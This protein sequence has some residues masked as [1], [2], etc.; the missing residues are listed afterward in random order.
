[1]ASSSSSHSSSSSSKS[2]SSSSA[3]SSSSSPYS[4]SSSKS[5]SSSSKSSSSSSSAQPLVPAFKSSSEVVTPN[6]G[7]SLTLPAPAFIIENN[8]LIAAV[9]VNRGQP[10]GVTAPVGWVEIFQSADTDDTGDENRLSVFYKLATITD[11]SAVSYTF[12]WSDI[13]TA[14]CGGI[15][16]YSGVSTTDPIDVSDFSTGSSA[17]PISP[18]VTASRSNTLVVRMYGC[19][20]ESGGRLPIPEMDTYP[21]Y[22]NGRFAIE[23]TLLEDTA[24]A[25]ADE[26]MISAGSTGIAEFFLST[27]DTWVAGTVV[28]NNIFGSSSS[29]SRSSSSSKSSSSR[30]SSSSSSHSS[31]SS[32]LSSSSSAS[33]I[34]IPDQL[35]K[36]GVII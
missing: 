7:F 3:S 2:S 30:S 16:L 32:S 9:S 4:S 23:S 8:L 34:F 29:S 28:L 35:P 25:L 11:E 19:D 33:I 5:S 24:V 1:M 17:T 22:T 21:L 12:D 18:S 14:A 36:K 13:S 15:A 6:V 20:A 27:T 10:S 31:S 26:D